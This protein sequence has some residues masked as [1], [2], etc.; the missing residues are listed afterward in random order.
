MN[1][2]QAEL[3]QR[4]Q[5]FNLDDLGD[6]LSFSKRLARENGWSA[7][8]SQEAIAEYKKFAFLAVVMETATPSEQVDQV[9]HLHLTYT[10]SYW[11]D[12]CPSTLPP[13]VGL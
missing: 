7:K 5:A 2:Q 12:F 3:Y 9:W 11:L 8:Y 1:S 13:F 10:H 6:D 4:I